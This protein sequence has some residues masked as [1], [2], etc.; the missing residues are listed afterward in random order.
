MLKLNTVSLETE[1]FWAKTL[2][3]CDN[4]LEIDNEKLEASKESCP[5]IE[6]DHAR[7]LGRYLVP[8]SILRYNE[9]D[10]PRDKNNDTDHVKALKDDF[11]VNGYNIECPP[12]ICCFDYESN[13]PYALKAQSG[14][15]RDAAYTDIGQQQIIVDIYDYENKM[16][17]VVARNKSNHHS[18]PRLVQTKNDYIKEVCNAVDEQTIENDSQSIDTFVDLIASDKT[19]TV[20][21]SIKDTCYN[22]CGTFPNFRTYNSSGTIKNKNSLKGFLYNYGLP[23]AGIDKRSDEQL[24]Q[25]GYIVYCAVSGGN[26][27]TWM[28]AI[29]HSTR[30]GIPIWI[31]GYADTRKP[32]LTNF[33]NNWIE[34]F[35]ELKEITIHFASSILDGCDSSDF[36]DDNFPIKV[37]GFLPQYIKPNPKDGGAPTEKG[38]VDTNGNPVVFDPDGDCLT[39]R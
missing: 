18:N 10:Q 32:D 17:E 24:I 12:P 25:K 14:F 30:L 16:W 3:G 19:T 26:K 7:Y 23:A 5:H 4:P 15:N 28:R 22:N 34:E 35:T 21:R 37:A 2:M 20:K 6:Y 29:T 31:I 9:E 13:S 27:A 36:D 11:D 38:L 39:T 33:R 8:R 1:A